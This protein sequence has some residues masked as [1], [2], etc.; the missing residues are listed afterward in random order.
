M[1]EY[2]KPTPHE[3]VI[4][5][6]RTDKLHKSLVEMRMSDLN[7][8]R[9]QHMMLRCINSFEEPPTQK[10]LSEKLD[11]SAATVAVTLKKLEASGY[12]S[13][14][15]SNGDSRCNKVSITK[16]GKDI[17]LKGKEIISEIDADTIRDLSDEELTVFSR[18]LL[19]IQENLR[20]SGAVIPCEGICTENKE[21]NEKQ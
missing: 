13:K 7:I 14:A 16:K 20:K 4:S 11:I 19:K 10:Q 1:E 21:R 8:H 5:F 6:I 3:L 18:C 17:L 2:K 12:I 15:T 9:S